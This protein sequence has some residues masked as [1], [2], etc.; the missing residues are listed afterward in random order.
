[1]YATES[2]EK[3][4][5]S[6]P[7]VPTPTAP[8][9]G[10]A[11]R[12]VGE[13]F[14]AN[15]AT[16]AGSFTVPVYTSPGR[17][18]FHPELSLSYDSGQGNGPFGLGWSLRVPSISRR[19]DK[20]LPRYS[21]SE[22]SDTFILSGAED[23]VPALIPD[24]SDWKRDAFTA[25]GESVVRYDAYNLAVVSTTDA[26][27]N[28]TQ[29]TI[30]Y[31]T[32]QP[33]LVTEP[34]GNR[35]AVAFDPLGQPVASALMGKDGGTDGD[36]LDDPTQR[37]EYDL[38]HFDQTGRPNFAHTSSRVQ[39]GANNPRWEE[40]FVYFDGAGREVMR[41]VHAAPGPAPKRDLN[42]SLVLDGNGKLVLEVTQSRWIGTGR[43]VVD[44]K[45]NAVKKYEP[46]FS[47]TSDYED[48]ADLVQWG[49]TPVLHY[50]ALSRLIRTDQPNGTFSTVTITPWQQTAADENDN[51]STSKWLLERQNLPPGDPEGRAAALTL[52]HANTP[53]VTNLDP[54]GRAFL[55][56]ADN[57]AD[58]QY[59][60]R[61]ALDIAGNAVAVTD[62]RGNTAVTHTFDMIGRKL[63][64]NSGDAGER[65]TLFDTKGK[66]LRTWDGRGVATR[67]LYDGLRR[68]TDLLTSTN[69]GA[70]SLVERT[71]YGEGAQDALLHNLR[72]RVYLQLDGSGVVTN[73]DYDFKGNLLSSSRQLVAQYQGVI[74]WQN[75][76]AN[77]GAPFAGSTAWDALNRPILQTLPNGRQIGLVYDQGGKLAQVTVDGSAY[78]TNIDYNP[79][80]QRLTISYGNQVTTSYTYDPLTFRLAE[81]LSTRPNN[82]NPLQDLSYTYDPVGNVVAIADAAQT[83]IFFAN[84]V[85]D[86]KA[87]YVYDA[88]Y[89]LTQATGREHVG[90]NGAI[91]RPE[92]TDAWLVTNLP[93]PNQPDAMR[94]Y[95]ERY[96]YDEVGNILQML[97]LAPD[98]QNASWTR[99]YR[100][101]EPN[102]RLSATTDDNDAFTLLYPHDA[103]GNMTAMPHLPAIDWDHANHMS[104][105]NRG[106]GGDVYFTY[107]AAGQRVRKVVVD[108]NGSLQSERI[109]L[110]AHELYREYTAGNLSLERESLHV[111]DDKRR[112]ALIERKTFDQG[113]INQPTSLPRYQLDNHLGSACLELDDEA[114]V[115]TYEEYHPYGTT[116][117]H[118]VADGV[119]VSARRY[120]YIGKERDDETGLYYHSARYCANWLARWISP[121]PAGAVDGFNLFHYS[122][123]NPITFHDPN[124]KQTAAPTVEENRQLR[125]IPTEHPAVCKPGCSSSSSQASKKPQVAPFPEKWEPI[126]IPE[127]RFGNAFSVQNKRLANIVKNPDES[128]VRKIGAVYGIIQ[129]IPFRG[130]EGLVF[131]PLYEAHVAFKQGDLD[132]GARNLVIATAPLTALSGAPA[133]SLLAEN[134]KGAT[135][136]LAAEEVATTPQAAKGLGSQLLSEEA[137]SVFNAGRTLH[138]D[139]LE[140]AKA[141]VPGEELGNPAVISALTKNG[142]LMS[143][144][145]KFTSATY[146]NAAGEEF[147]FHFYRNLKT[148]EVNYDVDYKMV[149]KD[150]RQVPINVQRVPDL[151]PGW[152]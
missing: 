100:S 88:I 25:N 78:V 65:W 10:G 62:A 22:E 134:T 124:G 32:L 34:N 125:S 99:R 150:G 27:A 148:G 118:A 123:N 58:G 109:Y 38:S 97:H 102:N 92:P 30:D 141:I 121:D 120:R 152:T 67:R 12:S 147:Q 103:V 54:L 119:E 86:A 112:V 49:V 6:G 69:Q 127:E 96:A 87:E 5:P 137:A 145:A 113:V 139:V 9:G 146:R 80:G 138:P 132:A 48:E 95:T 29:A 101:D 19:T 61:T 128:V 136:A 114:S 108:Q 91:V 122:R 55:A 89:R 93:E 71:V 126:P 63:Y 74:D 131:N 51:V 94:R 56:V 143:D 2:D 98:G 83:T 26:L 14:S 115:I 81:L 8:K 23:L 73:A 90:Q 37:F 42:G 116:A 52:A 151:A 46:F 16:G 57:G 149:F 64:A 47:S 18:G 21:D 39:H 43:T 72:G 85:V 82:P 133:G 53:A 77:S 17:A 106:G 45:G 117:Y 50:D 15:P 107:D 144:W 76:P 3:K 135:I 41:K 28:T 60:T 105:A 11:L 84:A 59:Q 1:M 68:P 33:S 111:L 110:G 142:S 104:H 35:A 31:S 36:T 40:A 20:G 13:K 75:P 70:E 130:I 7:Q 66:A 44:N 140:S 24:G 4:K 79:K 129:N